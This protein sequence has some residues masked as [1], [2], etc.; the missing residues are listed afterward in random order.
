MA[1]PRNSSARLES[2]WQHVQQPLFW[3]TADLRLTWVNRAWEQLTGST[4]EEVAG[5]TCRAHGPTRAGDLP[6]LVGS[7]FPPPEALA[8]QPASV[9]T[10][11]IHSSGERRWRR[12]EFRPFHDER[13]TL[14]GLF[15][16][17]GSSDAPSG[18]S[19]AES[20][21]LRTELLQVRERL[22]QRHGFDSLIGEGAVHRRLLDQIRTAAATSVPVL[23]VGEPGTGKRTVAR[24]IHHQGSHPHAPLLPID[25][26]ALPAEVME[27]ELFGGESAARLALPEGSSLLIGDILDLPR[28]LQGRL[29]ATLD[30]RIRLLATTAGDPETA[31]QSERLRP[32]LY[33]AV[34]TLIIRL[35]PLRER[36]EEIPLLAQHL[37]ER[38]NSRGGRQRGGFIESALSA[39][40][41]YDWPGNLREL[42]RVI[43]DVHEQAS[44]DLIEPDD[45]PAAIRG[46]LGS[47]YI[48]PPLPHPITPLDELLTQVER[49]LIEST[50]QRARQNKSRA[51]ELLGI[52]RPRLYR[53]IKE[54]GLPDVPE[55]AD[56][57]PLTNGNRTR[58]DG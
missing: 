18:N 11:I 6:G 47:A 30:P 23:I 46:N 57:V 44:G 35:R 42:A 4:A 54:L 58:E 41:A 3:L 12:I 36:V 22:Q 9:R 31:L 8:G 45:L 27:R 49:R 51:A 2:H 15:G 16:L 32:D 25:C 24:T 21:R 14:V 28:D 50:L 55:P 56:E 13:G 53:R 29:V 52:S 1:S 5:L 10:L 19:D 39:L 20:Q 7:F 38:A 43:E 33:Y 17:V 40:L 48:P 26:A 34:T 37:L